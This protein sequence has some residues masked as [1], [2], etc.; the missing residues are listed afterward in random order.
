LSAVL[1]LDIVLPLMTTAFNAL[2]LCCWRLWHDVS[3][4]LSV[5]HGCTAA[6]SWV[7]G[8]TF[9]TS[10]ESF[11]KALCVK[12]LGGCSSRETFWNLGPNWGGYRKN[13]CF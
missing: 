12:I 8:K 13:V 2:Q 7:T 10:N 1:G 9:Y 6:K 11:V 3:V 5:S 4:C